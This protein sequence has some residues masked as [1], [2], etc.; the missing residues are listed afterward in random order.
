M[1]NVHKPTFPE[2]NVQVQCPSCGARNSNVNVQWEDPRTRRPLSNHYGMDPLHAAAIVL[3]SG[4]VSFLMTTS[5][6]GPDA[7][8]LALALTALVS[9]GIITAYTVRSVKQ[10]ENAVRVYH[11]ECQYCRNKWSWQEGTSV[12]TYNRQRE[13]WEDYQEVF[14]HP[15]DERR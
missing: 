8:C 13:I 1:F 15:P 14:G 7:N 10:H 2:K 6:L 12:P 4:A 9:L 11:Y 3:V 5:W